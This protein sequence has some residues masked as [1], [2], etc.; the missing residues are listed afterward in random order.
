MEKWKNRKSSVKFINR[1][2]KKTKRNEIFNLCANTLRTSWHLHAVDKKWNLPKSSLSSP[3]Q[4]LLFS[5]INR[6][7]NRV[8]FD[9]ICLPAMFVSIK[10][11]HLAYNWSVSPLL[12]L[13]PAPQLYAQMCEN[14]K[15]LK[16]I[17]Y[18]IMRVHAVVAR[19]RSIIKTALYGIQSIMSKQTQRQ[20]SSNTERRG[21]WESVRERELGSKRERDFTAL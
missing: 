21:R 10:T 4:P 20:G 2:E 3:A 6:L 16:L 18:Y 1:T 19:G 9:I 5:G 7:G 17:V 13:S 8:V 11:K 15:G 14:N 12:Y